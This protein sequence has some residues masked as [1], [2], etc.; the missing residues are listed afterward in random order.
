MSDSKSAMRCFVISKTTETYSTRARVRAASSSLL[1]GY[2]GTPSQTTTADISTDV[3][4]ASCTHVVP[5]KRLRG[6]TPD[7]YVVTI[8]DDR[9]IGCNII[10]R[11]AQKGSRAVY[12]DVRAFFSYRGSE[13]L[14]KAVIRTFWR[15]IVLTCGRAVRR[16]WVIASQAFGVGEICRGE[17]LKVTPR[18]LSGAGCVKTVDYLCFL[19]PNHDTFFRLN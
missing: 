12:Y 11:F 7:E 9:S 15:F 8:V 6:P 18:C 1:H 3:R 2:S 16:L 5:T 4:I 10:I 14:L 19:I 13:L 17:K